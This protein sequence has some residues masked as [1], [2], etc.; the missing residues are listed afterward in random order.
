MS[1][2]YQYQGTI[3][4]S[5]GGCRRCI[6]GDINDWNK[7]PMAIEIPCDALAKYLEDRGW[8]DAEE[9]Y[10]TQTWIF[11]AN[12]FLCA[13]IIPSTKEGIPAKVIASKDPNRLSDEMVIFGPEALID[14]AEPE[15]MDQDERIRWLDFRSHFGLSPL[16]REE[17]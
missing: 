17:G 2:Y 3:S 12:L 1:R 4:V 14:T 6:L 5:E 7:P 10:I 8:T 16:N 9:R 13:V 15:P 11:D